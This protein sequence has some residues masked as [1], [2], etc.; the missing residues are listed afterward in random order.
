MPSPTGAQGLS[1]ASWI[2][3]DIEAAGPYPGRYA[4]LSLGACRVDEPEQAFYVECQP[5]K[6]EVDPHAMAVHGLTMVDL[7]ARGTASAAAMGQ[8]EAWL[9]E[10]VPSRRPIM[11]GFNTP[12][13]W[14]FVNHYFWEYRGHNPLGH[15]AID[16]KAFAMG[17]LG[18]PWSA[19]TFAQLAERTQLAPSL[20]HHAL[21]D[22]QQQAELLT[23]ILRMSPTSA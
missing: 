17:A 5:D 22:A 20:T 12:F 14:A 1:T 4:M 10:A 11:V 18:I 9:D 2:S 15:A 7:Q 23:C 16:I 13:D 8:F 21:A 19:T 6:D 3:V